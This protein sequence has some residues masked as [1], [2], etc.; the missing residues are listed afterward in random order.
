MEEHGVGNCMQAC[1]AM[2]F[3]LE[4]DQA[5]DTT[6]DGTPDDSGKWY[7][8]I[9]NWAFAQGYHL[10][11]QSVADG[12]E[13]PRGYSIASGPSPRGAFLHC[14]IALDGEPLLDPH[15]SDRLLVKVT[16]YEYIVPVREG[17]ACYDYIG[18]L[19]AW[20]EAQEPAGGV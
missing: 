9:I 6:N 1:L 13:P 12:V 4:L 19:R 14:C 20:R 11:Y 5:I 15:P 16:S 3:G 2:L 17:E 8:R 7:Q 10:V 18:H